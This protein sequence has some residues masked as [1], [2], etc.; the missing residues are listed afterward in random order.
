MK[1]DINE[2]KQ[3]N[4]EASLCVARRLRGQGARDVAVLRHPTGYTAIRSIDPVSPTQQLHHVSVSHHKKTPRITTAMRFA[5][6]I[7]PRVKEWEP[8]HNYGSSVI[9]IWEKP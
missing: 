7:Y 5:K 8:I 1:I 6:A 2:L 3:A 9:H 4:D